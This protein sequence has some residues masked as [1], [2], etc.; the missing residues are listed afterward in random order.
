MYESPSKEPTPTVV[1]QAVA[2]SAVSHMKRTHM[3][4]S[5]RTYDWVMSR[6]SNSHIWIPV[7]L[8]AVA[9]SAV[10]HMKKSRP[11]YE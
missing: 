3:N 7:V 5:C 11:I 8:Q 1:L 6:I 4:E 2:D 10:L 9:D